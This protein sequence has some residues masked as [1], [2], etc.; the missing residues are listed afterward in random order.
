M[1]AVLA[2]ACLAQKQC[3]VVVLATQDT[4]NTACSVLND[5]E[6][7]NKNNKQV[8]EKRKNYVRQ[9]NNGNFG[10]SAK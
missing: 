10:C 8:V 4:S 1:Y 5:V 3:V 9:C 2:V 7:E 6:N